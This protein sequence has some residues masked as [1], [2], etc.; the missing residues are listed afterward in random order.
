MTRNMILLGIAL[1]MF[2]CSTPLWSQQLFQINQ[3]SRHYTE[4]EFNL[5]DYE[6]I[7]NNINGELYHRVF[8][9]EAGLIMEEGLPELPVFTASII[10]PNTG[11]ISLQEITAEETERISDIRIFPSQGLNVIIDENRGFLL[12]ESFYNSDSSYPDFTSDISEPAIVRDFRFVTVAINPFSYNPA[13][14]ELSVKGNIRLRIEYDQSRIGDNETTRSDPRISRSFEKIYQ[15]MFLNYDE[16]RDDT[17]EYQARSILVIY[18]NSTILEP[19]VSQY[20]N[21]KRD[22]GFEITATSTAGMTTTTAIKNYIQNA[23]DT[24]EHPPEYIVLMGGGSGSFAIPTYT[25]HGAQGDHPY[26]LLEGN[27][28]IPDAF[29]GRLPIT[30]SDQLMTMWNKIRNYERE[31]FTG[32]TD[33]FQHT[34]LVGDS[35]TSSGVSPK[36]TML[37][38]RD[39]MLIYNEDYQFTEHYTGSAST[40]INN[41]FNQGISFFPFRGWLGMAGWSPNASSLNN[42]RMMP[43]CFF[44]TCNT[45]SF[46]SSS[47]TT[48]IVTMGTPLEPKG[49]IA[50]V[51]MTTSST[52]TTP[53]NA[54]VG[55]S[56]HA[57]FTDGVRTMGETLARAKIFLHE[58]YGIV[59]PSLPAQHTQK[60][61][62][63]GDPSMDI[64]IDVPKEMNV[65][66]DSDLPMGRNYID[67][68]VTDQ[69]GMP[70]E[71][72]WVTIRQVDDDE[73]IFATGYT[74]QDGEITH[75]FPP[76]NSGTVNVTVTKPDYTP[77]LGSFELTGEWAVALDEVILLD[78]FDA[79]NDVSLLLTVKNYRDVTAFNVEGVLSTDNPYV[80]IL[81]GS[82]SFG[83]LAPGE[84]GESIDQ[85]SISISQSA[86]DFMPVTFTLTKSESDNTWTSKFTERVNGSRLTPTALLIGDSGNS[87]IE[88]GETGMMRVTIENSGQ[89]DLEEVYGALRVWNPLLD[90]SDSL[91]YFGDI[92]A[93]ESVTS[94]ITDTFIIT[95]MEDLITGMSIDVE[96]Y[97]FNDN[98]FET[99]IETVIPI[100]LVTEDDPLGPCDYG[101]Y[102][103]GIE[104]TGYEHVPVYDWIEIA[105]QLGGSGVNTNLT[106]D[107]HNNQNVMSMDLPFTFS[108]YGIDYDEISICANG[109]ISFGVTEKNTWRNYI[110]P[111]ALGPNPIIAAFWDNLN[112]SGGGVYTQHIEDMF[113]IQWHN[114]TIPGNH[115]QNFQI[116]LFDP[117]SEPTIDD[118]LIKI[119]YKTFNNLNSGI[120]SGDWSNYSTIGIGDHTGELGLTYT[121][122]NQYPTAAAT[123]GNESALL[124]VGPKNYSEPFLIRGDILIFDENDNGIVEAGESVNIGIYVKNIGFATASDVTGTISTVS[125]YVSM[126]NNSST[127][128]DIH[129][130]DEIV[131]NDYFEFTI[132]SAT[133]DGQ[134]ISFELELQADNAE[135]TFP[136]H[137]N[138]HRPSLHLSSYLVEEVSG[139][140]NGIIDPGE[141]INLILVLNNPSLSEVDNVSITV[142]T[143]SEHISLGETNF[144]IGNIPAESNIQQAVPVIIDQNCPTGEIVD[145][146]IAVDANNVSSFN[147]ELLFGVAM[148]DIFIDFE[149][150]EAGFVTNDED[151]WQWGEPEIDPYSGD[152]VWGTVLNDNYA[153]GVSWTLDSPDFLITPASILEFF[154]YYA[155]EEYWDGGNVKVSTDGGESWQVIHPVDGYPIDNTNSGNTGI[156]N[157]PAFSGNS[158]GW[159]E[160]AY[161]L[162][163]LFGQTGRFRWHFGS[164]PW[165]NDLGWFIDDVS[166]SGANPLYSIVTGQVDLLQSP[167]AVNEVIIT[168]G[169]F[170]VKPDLNG[171]YTLI[172]PPGEYVVTASL[173]YHF[174][175]TEYEI[176]I[177]ELEL[178]SDLD[179]SLQY[180]TPP[181]NLLYT[182]HNDNVTIDL[183]WTF[184]PLP[185]LNKREENRNSRNYEHIFNIYRQKNSGH[186][187][188]IHMTTDLEYTDIIN[189]GT[190]IYRYYVV[191][192]YDVGNSAKTNIVGTD[193][194]EYDV[195]DELTPPVEFAL[196]QNYPNPFNPVTNI[197]FNLPE[198]EN[199][200]LKIYNIKGELVGT[201][202]D[203][204]FPAGEHTV[205]WEGQNNNHRKVSSGIYFYR[206]QAGRHSDVRKAVLLK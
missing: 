199:V 177:D 34:L 122:A 35:T 160:A 176:T 132:S 8:H 97:L 31:P 26:G 92:D 80:E 133:P 106:S 172:V 129:T 111:G 21:W 72:A 5:D 58:T 99:T 84:V 191:A 204:V 141:E 3:T 181:E 38:V 112:L 102:I 206:I 91:A 4:I 77:H 101:Y 134:Y 95:A 201:L 159:Q 184:E 119:Q 56:F 85:Y 126:I 180:L 107:W 71:D 178:I 113:I 94:S 79:G 75:I 17:W 47:R 7:T 136:F 74:N 128:D 9:P 88:P 83:D 44:I 62:L 63:M 118:G 156:P 185:E 125:P 123:L 151:G 61:S 161:D 2:T 32:N 28:D 187:E 82:S 169:E 33:W 146:N 18:H 104:D 40:V 14:S 76:D 87:Y 127:Y 23:Y 98:G 164:G 59:H 147:R 60:A 27:D 114:A 153:D 69:F 108:Y 142:T 121:F 157:Q 140:G 189:I 158:N 186:F 100:G 57:I 81:Q 171:H 179:F 49:A 16:I 36:D 143:Q 20:V 190:D 6:L 48:D 149:D 144:D 68:V 195:E 109:W 116:I 43:N 154:H 64:W 139:N 150:D 50:A 138:V 65:D 168:A 90:V 183:S 55:S 182:L 73:V 46:T 135:V 15:S 163:S 22:K 155:I 198:Q 131:N 30:T 192:E 117:D 173:P 89:I 148:E 120:T 162:S 130:G 67:F 96:L 78:D 196:R 11:T 166:L 145:L 105:P 174:E 54:I 37:Y 70:V 193:S 165:V 170:S 51:G 188:S 41:A 93:G 12:D 19:I 10:V 66:Y 137:I 197:S 115:V 205:Q 53:N 110:L 13:N 39:L 124:I 200:S 24:W 25:N 202:V 1:I 52:R 152:N 194:Q 167:V 175:E 29:V 45:L 42:G 86:P 203:E 103:Y